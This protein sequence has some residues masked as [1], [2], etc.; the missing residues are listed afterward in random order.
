MKHFADEPTAAVQE[1]GGISKVWFP[2]GRI[3]LGRE[4]GWALRELLRQ[5]VEQPYDVRSDPIPAPEAAQEAAIWVGTGQAVVTARDFE[6]A[7][8]TLRTRHDAGTWL[9]LL[10]SS[11]PSAD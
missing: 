7:V 8:N 11:L 1:S 9:T 5:P 4:A 3:V 10:H 6:T 2:R